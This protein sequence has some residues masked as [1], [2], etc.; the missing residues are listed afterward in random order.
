M[1]S[2]SIFPGQHDDETI[3]FVFRQHPVVMRKALIYGLLAILIAVLPLDFPGI[4]AVSWLPSLLVKIV[5]A[6]CVLVMAFWFHAWVKWYYSICIVTNKRIVEIRQMGLFKRRVQ[7][8][9]HEHIQALNYS[10]SGLSAV[11]FHY[12]DI[13]VLTNVGNFELKYVPHPERLH[14]QIL[15]VMRAGG[16]NLVNSGKED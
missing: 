1:S 7:A 5:L 2:R 3:A 11:I 4:Y 9:F 13:R 16:K 8:L 6:V 10:I 15:E 12:G 14:A